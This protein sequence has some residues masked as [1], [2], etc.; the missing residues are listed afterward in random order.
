MKNY[1]YI[2][3]ITLFKCLDSLQLNSFRHIHDS[4]IKISFFIIIHFHFI[5]I[6]LKKKKTTL[7]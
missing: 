2:I 6:F 3:N 4:D 7:L 1:V 5:I